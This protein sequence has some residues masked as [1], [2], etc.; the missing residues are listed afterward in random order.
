[1][2]LDIGCLG[3]EKWGAYTSRKKTSPERRV[4]ELNKCFWR[5][6]GGLGRKE[7]PPGWR[8]HPGMGKIL[9]IRAMRGG[10]RRGC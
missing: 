1:M 10:K 2:L 3:L 9:E 6:A 4:P 5:E 7:F 8:K